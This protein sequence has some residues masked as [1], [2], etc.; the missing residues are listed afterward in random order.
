MVSSQTPQPSPYSN[1]PVTFTQQ[2]NQPQVWPGW[3]TTGWH[4]KNGYHK[5]CNNGRNFLSMITKFRLPKVKSMHEILL[6][7][8][9]STDQTLCL[10]TAQNIGPNYLTRRCRLTW[11]R[12]VKF[13]TTLLH[14]FLWERNLRNT[15]SRVGNLR[16][17][18]QKSFYTLQS[19][20]HG[21]QH[22]WKASLDRSGSR[23]S[24]GRN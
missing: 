17:Y 11:T 10:T 24:K 20:M 1:V 21:S 6:K 18:L 4:K 13:A 2:A 16:S 8:Q 23:A 15:F 22:S 9:S 19:A 5:I 12:R 3:H 14:S 7:L